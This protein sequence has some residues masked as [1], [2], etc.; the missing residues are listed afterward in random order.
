MTDPTWEPHNELINACIS[1]TGSSVCVRQAQSTT[2]SVSANNCHGRYNEIILPC[3]MVMYRTPGQIMCGLRC[4][5]PNFANLYWFAEDTSLILW[6]PIKIALLTQIEMQS[7][8]FRGPCF[9]TATCALLYPT[10][11]KFCAL[12][13]AKILLTLQCC[14]ELCLK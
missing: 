3:A 13:R 4:T 10:W 5:F 6:Q 14:K 2:D 12:P 8:V 11:I 7:K 1:E 9:L